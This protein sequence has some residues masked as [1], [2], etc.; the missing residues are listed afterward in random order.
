MAYGYQVRTP[1][2]C[3]A[4]L[5]VMLQAGAAL[6]SD[7]QGDSGFEMRLNATRKEPANAS[8]SDTG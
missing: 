3:G 2:V 5:T 4:G 7:M 6:I 1:I 8:G